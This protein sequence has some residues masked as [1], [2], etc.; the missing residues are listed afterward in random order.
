MKDKDKLILIIYVGL[1][2][3]NNIDENARMYAISDFAKNT[4]DDSVKCI[5][6]PDRYLNYPSIT[7]KQL[8][9]EKVPLEELDKALEKAQYFAIQSTFLNSD[10]IHWN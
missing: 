3:A 6:I 7:I 1:K 4:F 2:S 8:N 10:E 5:I 9:K